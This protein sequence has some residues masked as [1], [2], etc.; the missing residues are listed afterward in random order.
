M[1]KDLV[2]S[3]FNK[4]TIIGMA[5]RPIH[6]KKKR[7]Y[8][9]CR[10]E[11][12]IEKVYALT[13]VKNGYVKSCGCL[14]KEVGSKSR[15][16][17]TFEFVEDYVVCK[18]NNERSFAVDVEDY[19]RIVDFGRYWYVAG[20]KN[21]GRLEPY[22]YSCVSGKTIRL[23]NF[24]MNPEDDMIVDHI[25]GNPTNNRRSNLRLCTEAQNSKN[26]SIQR[27]NTSG[28]KGV[29]LNKKSGKWVSRIS[30]DGK[31]I[32]LGTFDKFD[33]AVNARKEAD[34]KYF[35]EFSRQDSL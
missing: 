17:N 18:D 22:V 9:L 24:I 2:G 5:E 33:D 29:H 27:N 32:V 21:K 34:E 13:R 10:C 14:T 19:Y 12:G 31:R 23:H 28:H 35:G 6:A 15:H 3:K 8:V 30:V 4:L 7:K 25:D 11:C 20:R 16:V 1:N 26:K